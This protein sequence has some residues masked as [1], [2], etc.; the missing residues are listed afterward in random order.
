MK[1]TPPLRMTTCRYGPPYAV[2]HESLKNALTCRTIMWSQNNLAYHTGTTC[3][4]GDRLD[5]G[6]VIGRMTNGIQVALKSLSWLRHEFRVS[7]EDTSCPPSVHVVNGI[8]NYEIIVKATTE[9]AHYVCCSDWV[10]FTSWSK[11]HALISSYSSLS[12]T[13]YSNNINYIYN[14]YKEKV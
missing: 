9:A 12:A 10:P 4:A 11:R 1:A 2:L 3:P 5:P 6:R 14:L 7:L 8:N 13:C